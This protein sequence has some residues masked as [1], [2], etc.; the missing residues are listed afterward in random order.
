MT[1]KMKEI[2]NPYLTEESIETLDHLFSAVPPD[3]LRENLM[4]LY[5]GY[6]VHAHCKL[7]GNFESIA[8]NMYHLIHCLADVKRE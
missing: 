2:S 5:H 7:P 3:E 4:E 8:I 1:N 6:L